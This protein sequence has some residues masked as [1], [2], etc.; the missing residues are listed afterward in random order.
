MLKAREHIRG[1]IAAAA[2]VLYGNGAVGLPVVQEVRGRHADRAAA[3][4][5]AVAD[6]GDRRVAD[7]VERAHLRPVGDGCA[8]RCHAADTIGIMPRHGKRGGVIDIMRAAAQRMQQNAATPFAAIDLDLMVH[9]PAEG[10]PRVGGVERRVRHLPELGRENGRCG[11]LGQAGH[12][13]RIR[14][15]CQRRAAIVE[16][17]HAPVQSLVRAVRTEGQ[18]H[19]RGIDALRT[20]N[21]RH[22]PPR[23]A[24][25]NAHR[26][27]HCAGICLPMQHN[28]GS[29]RV[30][31]PFAFRLCLYVLCFARCRAHLRR[32]PIHLSHSSRRG[33]RGK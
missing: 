21:R 30:L 9:L 8:R 31:R 29:A 3:V 11:I 7:D 22:R 2:E 4:R 6:R 23:N 17:L 13:L 1:R 28:G 10:D 27:P 15:L 5:D 16:R 26:V 20:H 32:S 14:R 33:Q 18:M 19:A 12:G 25:Q 24:A